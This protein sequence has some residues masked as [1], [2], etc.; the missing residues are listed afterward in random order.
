MFLLIIVLYLLCNDERMCEHLG[1]LLLSITLITGVLATVAELK[2]L[3]V[4]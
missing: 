1:N 2:T 3:Y 4:V